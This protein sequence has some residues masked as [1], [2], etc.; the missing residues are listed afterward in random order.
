MAKQVQVVLSCDVH[1][2]NVTD[3]VTTAVFSVEGSRYEVDLCTEHAEEF[4]EFLA[5]YI[6]LG[7]RSGAKRKP[8]VPKPRAKAEVPKDVR[9][10]AREQGM[11]VNATGQVPRAVREA[12]AAAR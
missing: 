2:G 9:T 12:Y 3:G 6:S 11:K 1:K 10:W 5:T 7:R 4:H 8:A